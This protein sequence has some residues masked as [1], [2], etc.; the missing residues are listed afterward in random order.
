ML[1]FLG[2]YYKTQSENKFIWRIDVKL[3]NI[4]DCDSITGFRSRATVVF[5]V[6]K[7]KLGSH[8]FKD[9]RKVKTVITP[10]LM[11]EDT[12]LLV[13]QHRIRQLH[14]RYDECLKCGSDYVEERWD[15]STV[16]FELYLL[17][18]QVKNTKYVF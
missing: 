5:P 4:T 3:K 17:L 13:Y 12:D 7:Q 1:T 15:S 6:L 10:W 8:R 11:T 18:F 2:P 14:L 16:T 9:D